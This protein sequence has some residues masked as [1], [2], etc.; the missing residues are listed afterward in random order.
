MKHMTICIGGKVGFITPVVLLLLLLATGVAQAWTDTKIGQIM[1]D[2]RDARDFAQTASSRAL[3]A[4]NRAN[5]ILSRINRGYDYLEQLESTIQ[6]IIDEL[7]DQID[8]LQEGRA[9]FLGNNCD[10]HSPCGRFSADLV[11]LLT[12]IEGM[13]NAIF[14]ATPI[15]V[16]VDFQ[17]MKRL[18]EHAPGRALYPL[19]RVLASEIPIM[20]SSFMDSLPERVSDLEF[21]ADVLQPPV[22]PTSVGDHDQC[23]FLL[24]NSQRADQAIT[25][26][27]GVG[28]ALLGLGKLLIAAGETHLYGKV[29]IHGYPGIALKNNRLKKLGG[30]SA[31]AGHGVLA[32]T[33]AVSNK[34]RYCTMVDSNEQI[35]ANQE[36]ILANQEQLWNALPPGWKVG[37]GQRP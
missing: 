35:L 13:N 26:S 6:G 16:N 17:R 11:E 18:I 31:G 21:L 2:A 8:E 19:Y 20:E 34:L 22:R 12:G 32:I 9:E 24:E 30:V 15:D 23:E 28:V 33:G 1:D 37:I 10:F 7:K 5:T 29:G 3:D 25:G 4:G 27:T 14:R 36:R